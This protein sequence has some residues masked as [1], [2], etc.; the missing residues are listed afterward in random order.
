MDDYW[1]SL[2][3]IS[4]I[5]AHQLAAINLQYPIKPDPALTQQQY[6]NQGTKPFYLLKVK[7]I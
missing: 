6:N 4:N 2:G 1:N 3:G 5:D 7:E